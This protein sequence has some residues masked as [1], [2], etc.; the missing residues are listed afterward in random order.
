LKSYP[1]V[2]SSGLRQVMQHVR[3]R[4]ADILGILVVC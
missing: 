3:A 4:T 2:P 1:R